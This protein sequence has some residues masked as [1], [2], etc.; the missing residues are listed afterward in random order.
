M[1]DRNGAIEQPD[2]APGLQKWAAGNWPLESCAVSSCVKAK[3]DAQPKLLV[4]ERGWKLEIRRRVVHRVCFEDEERL[5][6]ALAQISREV[7][8]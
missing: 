2:I 6:M 1:L 8:E 7:G 4:G 5:D 3:M